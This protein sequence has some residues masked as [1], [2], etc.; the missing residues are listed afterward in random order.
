M[1][2]LTAVGGSCLF[3]TDALS[4][5]T[6]PLGTVTPGSDMR[7]LLSAAVEQGAAYFTANPKLIRNVLQN[8]PGLAERAGEPDLLEP[9]LWTGPL[10]RTYLVYAMRFERL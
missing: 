7:S 4:S 9:W 5:S 1:V 6:Y 10:E 3:T 2:E 8:D